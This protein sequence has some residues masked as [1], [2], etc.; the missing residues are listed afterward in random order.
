[1]AD[2]IVN[3]GQDA[4]E[5]LIEEYRKRPCLWKIKSKDYHNRIKRTDALESLLKAVQD[6][7]D[8]TSGLKVMSSFKTVEVLKKKIDNLRSAFRREHGKVKSS[9][10]SDVGA[11]EVYQPSLWYYQNLLFIGEMEEARES[12][13]NLFEAPNSACE[14][15][16]VSFDLLLML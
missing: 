14:T 3:W 2:K 12:S 8:P 1:M 16:Q 11:E 9:T 15:R 4:I 5:F 13:S 7:E 10:K 6:F